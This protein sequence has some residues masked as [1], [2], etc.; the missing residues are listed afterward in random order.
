M[1]MLH[2]AP[3]DEIVTAIVD[4]MAD[5]NSTAELAAVKAQTDQLVSLIK[6]FREVKKKDVITLDFVN[7]ET[8][9][10]WN[11]RARGSIAGEAF[12]RALTRIWLGDKP[13][14]DDLKQALLRGG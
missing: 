11:G 5:N 9:L 6:R 3:S 7:G 14:Q 2:G 10:R 12:N 1:N 13:V 8:R 4:T